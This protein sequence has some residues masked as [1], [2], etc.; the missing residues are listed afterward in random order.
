MPIYSY[1]L[2]KELTVICPKT[3]QRLAKKS[4]RSLLK[5]DFLVTRKLI[6]R[7]GIVHHGCIRWCAAIQNAAIT[8]SAIENLISRRREPRL[9]PADQNN[10]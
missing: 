10:P 8:A 2:F 1:E 4:E 3:R 7:N 5:I 6:V 9:V